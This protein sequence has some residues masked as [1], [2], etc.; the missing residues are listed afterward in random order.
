MASGPDG[1]G[2]R[3]T[4]VDVAAAAGVS[5]QTVS[6]VLNS[7]DRVAPQTLERV[8]REIERLGFAPNVA[9]QQLR[10]R[11]ASAYGFEVD[12]SG[13]GR[14]GQILERFLV[15]MTMAAPGHRSHLV[16]FAPDLDQLAEG[17]SQMLGTGL[18]DGFFLG[19]TRRGDP[20]PGWLLDN[21]VPFVTFG[22]IWDRPDLGRWVDIDGRAGMARAVEHLVAQGYDTVAYL[23][24]PEGSPLGDDRRRGWLTGLATAGLAQE[25]L[26][27][28]AVQDVVAAT[29]AAHRL[30]DRLP[31]PGLADQ[32]SAILCVS[33]VV[34]LG[35]LGALTERG[36]Q[37]GR[38]VGLVGFDDLDISRAIGL[39]SL[40]QP[41]REAAREAWQLVGRPGHDLQL[42]TLLTPTLMERASS[43]PTPRPAPDP[44]PITRSRLLHAVTPQSLGT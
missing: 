22:R 4:I 40:R 17:Y 1:H 11:R 39:T 14:M 19:D 18:V 38:D 13:I 27:E 44:T 28:V 24:W 12:P 41:L 34:A 5:R 35:A 42:S 32:P 7:P 25:P 29:A 43:D 16:T 3:A 23:G 26:S 36:L 30:L 37:A 6:N 2:G 10:R 21:K 33:D 15:E 20:R 31:P 8:R 9:A